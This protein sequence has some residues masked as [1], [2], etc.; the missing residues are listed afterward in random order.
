MSINWTSLEKKIK[1][2]TM[3][4]LEDFYIMLLAFVAVWLILKNEKK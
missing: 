4:D 1:F 2:V 3:F